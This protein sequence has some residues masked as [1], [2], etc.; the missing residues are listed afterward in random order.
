M[1][2]QGM[3]ALGGSVGEESL[4]VAWQWLVTLRYWMQ[5]MRLFWTRCWKEP[6]SWL[7]MDGFPMGEWESRN[8][9]RRWEG[10]VALIRGG[11]PLF[12]DN[13]IQRYSSSPFGSAENGHATQTLHFVW[14]CLAVANSDSNAHL[15]HLSD[16]LWKFTTL[17]DHNGFINRNNYRVEY[18]NGDGVIGEP[19]WRTAGYLLVMNA[20]RKNLAITGDAKYR[21]ES[22]DIPVTYH[23]DVAGKNQLLRSWSIV[24]AHLGELAPKSLVEGIDAL[25]ALPEG[26]RLGLR[27]QLVW[28]TDLQLAAG[29]SQLPLPLQAL[30]PRILLSPCSQLPPRL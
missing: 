23:R 3:V 15:E 11:A 13:A 21:R 28:P 14:G 7:R 19:Y 16:Y 17:R 1:E 26:E 20:H 30:S 12:V 8:L 4:P 24:E 5:V 22:R 27:L 25:E 2:D 10:K 6:S 9:M 18:H 29:N